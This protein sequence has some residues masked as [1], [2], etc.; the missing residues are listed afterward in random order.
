MYLSKKREK[1]LGILSQF[2]CTSVVSKC[3]RAVLM[4]G[5]AAEKSSS[6]YSCRYEV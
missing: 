1:P 2:A 4:C 5:L 6:S 3:E